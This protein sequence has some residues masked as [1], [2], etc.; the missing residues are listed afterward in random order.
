MHRGE[1]GFGAAAYFTAGAKAA[2]ASAMTALATL[3]VA[4]PELPE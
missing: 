1:S 3:T 2:I 4:V